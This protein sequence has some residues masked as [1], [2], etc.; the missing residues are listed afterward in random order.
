M[1]LWS[2]RHER[3]WFV[4]T[5][6]LRGGFALNGFRRGGLRTQIGALLLGVWLC[7]P[8]LFVAFDAGEVAG[9]LGKG[10]AA[11]VF[12]FGG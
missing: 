1:G 5:G 11:G 3:I 2:D 12:G 9:L 8:G 10:L 4:Q 7:G 6:C